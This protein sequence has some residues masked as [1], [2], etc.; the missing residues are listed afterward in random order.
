[1]AAVRFPSGFA[2]LTLELMY[3]Q[4]HPWYKLRGYIHFDLPISIKQAEAIATSPKRVKKHSFYPFISYEIKS[5]K[6]RRGDDGLSLKIKEKIRPVSYAA[7]VDSHIY[8]Y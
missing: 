2:E 5:K 4:N 3:V 7:H 8:T 1:M 6:V